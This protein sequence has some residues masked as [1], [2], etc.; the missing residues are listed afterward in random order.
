MPGEVIHPWYFPQGC[1]L[2]SRTG[3][4]YH[5]LDCLNKLVEVLMLPISTST[6]DESSGRLRLRTIV[7]LRWI[8]VIGQAVTVAAV[9]FGFGFELP[10]GFCG[11]AIAVSAWLNIFLRIRYEG[12]IWLRSHLSSAML[13]YDIMQ[14]ACPL[15][16]QKIFLSRPDPL[17]RHFFGKSPEQT[18]SCAIIAAIHEL[19]GLVIGVNRHQ[20]SL[21]LEWSDNC[22]GTIYLLLN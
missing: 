3:S 1:G 8:A 11:L 20:A 12:R 16:A 15:F 19:S 13:A 22:K 14:L 17:V 4:N 7:R 6:T 10:I 18:K 5:L 9:Y 2:I 21:R